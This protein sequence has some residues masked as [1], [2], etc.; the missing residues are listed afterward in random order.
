MLLLLTG[1][2]GVTLTEAKQ[3]DFLI[4]LCSFTYYKSL[5]LEIVGFQNVKPYRKAITN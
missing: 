5:N 1:R 3:R 2:G 4:A